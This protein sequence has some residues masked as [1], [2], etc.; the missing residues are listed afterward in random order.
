VI[1]AALGSLKGPRH[2]GANIKVMQMI[3]DLKSHV[4][5]V[6]DEDAVAN[7]LTKL[8]HKEVFDQAGLIYGVG[9]AV[10]SVSD[11]RAEVFKDFVRR[12]A[13][14]KHMDNE[15]ALYA[16][17]EKLAPGLIAGDRKMYKGVNTNV[18]FYSG[19]VYKLLGLPSELF[20]P[21]FAVARVAGWSAHRLEEL[22]SAEKIIRPAYKA[23]APRRGYEKLGE[24]K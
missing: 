18:D 23:I 15:Y 8:L 2:G 11:P 20:T 16:T 13:H 5:D 4:K 9:H 3:D 22:V 19:F 7:Y 21:M 14:E 1:A 12:L 10:Y 6:K 17:I 24:R